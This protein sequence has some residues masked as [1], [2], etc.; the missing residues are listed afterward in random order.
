MTDARSVTVSHVRDEYTGPIFAAFAF[1]KDNDFRRGKGLP[2][3]IAKVGGRGIPELAPL[4][5][6]AAVPLHAAGIF[7]L[8]G[9]GAL[10]A[11]RRLRAA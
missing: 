1:Y 11:L 2:Y 7:T 6:P 10:M 8:A 4:P 3:S 5:T 9:L